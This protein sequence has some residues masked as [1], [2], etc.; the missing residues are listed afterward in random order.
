VTA[1]VSHRQFQSWGRVVRAGHA[2]AAPAYC[3][4]VGELLARAPAASVLA[5]GLG[6]SYGDSCLNAGGAL[7]DMTRLDRL[8]AFDPA[9]GVVRA[10]AGMMLG[11]LLRVVV[12]K[13]WFLPTT[14]GTRYVTLGGA[15]ASDVHGK[16]HH[17]AGSLGCSVRRL[18][19][20]RSDGELHELVP[21][22]ASGLFEATI[23]GLGLTGVITSVELQLAPIRSAFIEVERIPF[24]SVRE[25][26]AL[27]ADSAAFEHTVAWIDC[28]SGGAA[29]G[30]GM[31][32]RA[33][34]LADGELAPHSD[35]AL[36]TVPVAA[37]ELT[38]HPVTVRLFNALYWRLQK[39]GAPRQRM[40]YAPFFYPLDAIGRWNLLYGARGLY[41]YQCVVPPA[42]TPG[43]VEELLRQ[44]ARMAAGSFLAVLKTLGSRRS[45]GLISF[46][47]EGATLALDFPNRGADTL[48]LLQ[49]LDEIVAQAGGRLYAAKDGRMPAA[50]FKAGYPE[51]Q[52]FARHVDPRFSSDFWRRV[53]A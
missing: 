50:M 44:I 11:E 2:I 43:A 22:G 29:L 1:F 12:P 30:R 53:S 27:A 13:G 15:V 4:Q 16:N 49:R 33:R 34:W 36:A 40:H 23:G 42:A 7:I 32:Q 5:V 21:G 46:P 24:P 51:W 20:V 39:A 45:P 38:L 48:A 52:R 10:E 9:S 8:I 37:P 31:F 14:P 25:F 41:Q 47:M 28:A 3:D 17:G 19:I 6:R 18:E 26:F 35:T